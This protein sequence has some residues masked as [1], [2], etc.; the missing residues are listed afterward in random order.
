M[1]K[2][3]EYT[4]SNGLTLIV[5]RDTSTP[6][7]AVNI[8]YNVGAKDE[9]PS[10]TGFAHLFEHLMFGGSIN[11]PSYD[12]PLELAGGE[13]NAFT[14]T[15]ITNY[16]LSLPAANLETAFW[17]ESDRM[18]NLAFSE[19]SLEVQRNVVMEE[20]KQR[21][22]NQPYGDTWLLL[23]PL[24]FKKHP[25]MW[26]TIGKE[27]SHIADATM[28]DVK[29]FYSKFYNPCNAIV[30]V[31]GNVEPEEVCELAEKWFGPIP[32]GKPYQRNLPQE[33][34]QKEKAFLEVERDV[35]SDAIF[36][37]W[38]MSGR[39]EEKYHATDL[40][41]DILSH[42]ESS[43]FTQKLIKE[44]QLFSDLNAYITGELD[45]GLFVISG[46][47]NEG[48]SFERAENAIYDELNIIKNTPPAEEEL[49]KTKN[50]IESILVFS[51]LKI[52]TI[53]MNLCVAKLMG[54]TGLVNSELEKYLRVTPERICQEAKAIFTPE[55]SSILHYKSK[56]KH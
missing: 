36:M 46:K 37:A 43:R 53:A 41:S 17:L 31:A 24:A 12:E 28:E 11:I 47:L 32:A 39:L 44:K 10:R 22:L 18:L 21:Y 7:A 50:K 23:R 26:P 56:N 55:N 48:V 25:Y 29:A 1:I 9:H 6:M 16:Y 13:N 8:L 34:Q 49:Q 51:E 45:P 5:H 20:F 38:H 15:D 35:P 30:S 3:T 4:L 33:P 19:K 40:I 27:L 52:T 14:S 2:Y 42:G 54:D